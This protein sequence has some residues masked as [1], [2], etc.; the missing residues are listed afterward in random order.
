MIDI[1]QFVAISQ[2]TEEDAVHF[3][4]SGATLQVGPLKGLANVRALLRTFTPHKQ[5]LTL[6]TSP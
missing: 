5:L 4:S 6:Q 3:L 2:A 1:E